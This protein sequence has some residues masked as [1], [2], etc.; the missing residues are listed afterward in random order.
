VCTSL[1]LSKANP[2][3]AFG[4]E[5]AYDS[6][7]PDFAATPS[8]LEVIVLRCFRVQ[9]CPGRLFITLTFL[10]P[11]MASTPTLQAQTANIQETLL[12]PAK[13]AAMFVVSPDGGHYAAPAMH[14]THEVVVID[15]VDGPEFDHAGH[16]WN[17]EALDFVFSPDGKHSCYV[18]QS[19]DDMVLV[20]DGKTAFKILTLKTLPGNA[21]QGTVVKVTQRFVHNVDA[22][23]PGT[24]AGHRCLLSPS[25]EHVA[26]LSNEANAAES[27]ATYMFLDGVKSPAWNFIDPNQVAFVAEKLVYA[28]QNKDHTWHLVA[29]DKPGPTYSG[30]KLLLVN[31]DNS[32]YAFVGSTGA[33]GWGVG[34]DGVLGT[35]RSIIG[36][37]VIASNGRVAYTTVGLMNGATGQGSGSGLF[38]DDKLVG[39]P[40]HRFTRV[41]KSGM[42]KD[43]AGTVVFSPDGKRVA[44]VKSAAGAV[45]PV[46]DGKVGRTYD[47]IR[48]IQFSPDSTHFYYVGTHDGDIV[49]C[50]GQEMPREDPNGVTNFIFSQTGG[51]F[52]YLAKSA[53]PGTRMV[54]DGKPSKPFYGLIPNSM[55]FSTGGN[56]YAYAVHSN[57]SQ[58]QFVRDGVFAN[59]SYLVSFTTRTGPP[60]IDFP[61]LI[62][63]PDGTRLAWG[64]GKTDGVSKNV[65]STDG[66]ELIHGYSTYEFPQFSPDG[67]HFATMI[68][69][70]NKYF[71][72]MD[73]KIGTPYDDF[74]EVNRNVAR[75]IDSH[76][77]R[78]LGVKNGS[79][80]RVTVN[81]GG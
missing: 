24:A 28:A 30:L 12:G 32:H 13:Q 71:L 80:Y 70:A 47:S 62:F 58:W 11:L 51:H 46:I 15:G 63:S 55:T 73:G 34:V 74:L 9:S 69:N 39:T 61:P 8:L 54:V 43:V 38:I 81:T 1:G 79:V 52:A 6:H 31:D 40:D 75:F 23:M 14:G 68:W 33:T 44:Y 37:V 2:S 17:G 67:G 45:A 59:V 48:T 20:R 60:H 27:G 35:L 57:V 56:H 19:G 66:Q 5:E 49:V 16:T 25:G 41:D 65:I 53:Q 50:D 22:Q 76:T 3:L 36:D 42:G 26:V 64:F 78:F 21:K 77:F 29:N 4:P 18:A 10:T 72:A 7:L